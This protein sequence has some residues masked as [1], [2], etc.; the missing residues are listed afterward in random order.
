MLEGGGGE[1]Y[2]Y[3]SNLH[4]LLFDIEY[5]C[6]LRQRR[7]AILGH[8]HRLKKHPRNNKHHMQPYP[9][10]R[11]DP[12]ILHGLP[13]RRLHPPAAHTVRTDQSQ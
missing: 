4:D 7:V 11:G 8:L 13:L 3:P 10:H 9:L 12:K 5:H 2:N 6:D 1:L